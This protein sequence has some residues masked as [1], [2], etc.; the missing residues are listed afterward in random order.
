M[1]TRRRPFSL[2]VG[3]FSNGYQSLAVRVIRCRAHLARLRP[4]ERSPMFRPPLASAETESI[5]AV[6]RSGS[7]HA[8]ALVLTHPDSSLARTSGGHEKC[9]TRFG[10]LVGLARLA[11][12]IV[13]AIVEDK[14]PEHLTA[15]RLMSKPLPLSWQSSG[16]SW[17]S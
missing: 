1:P 16:A 11:P 17:A 13:T 2:T 6:L 15:H 10:K 5:T 14:Q 12:D 8:R 3:Y 7:S 4:S 9:R